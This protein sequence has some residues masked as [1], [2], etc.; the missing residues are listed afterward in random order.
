[1]LRL[2][3]PEQ[4]REAVATLRRPGAKKLRK[5]LDRRTFAF[6][7]PGLEQHFLP[8][9]RSAGL[10]KP[11]TNTYVNGFEVDFYWPELKLVVETDGLRYH[12]TPQQ[13]AKDRIRDQT[14]TAAG[15][16][17]LRFTHDQIKFEPSRVEETLATVAAH[18]RREDDPKIGLAA[19]DRSLAQA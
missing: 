5:L 16:T 19:D 18:L 9:A 15:F 11:R 8:I 7:R 12:R 3:D 17:C 1:V 13:Q 14:H 2:I 10:P 6:T 4:L